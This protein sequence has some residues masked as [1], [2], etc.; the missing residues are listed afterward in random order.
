MDY[1]TKTTEYPPFTP[2]P[3][4]LFEADLSATAKLTY[5]VLLNRA[6]LSRSNDWIDEQGRVFVVYPI[7]ALGKALKKKRTVVQTAMRDLEACDRIQRVKQGLTHP[8][9]IYVKIDSP[10]P[11]ASRCSEKRTSDVRKNGRQMFGKPATN[12]NKHNYNKENYTIHTTPDLSDL[13]MKG[14]DR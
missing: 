7:E 11:S 14:D 10:A 13:L 5:L 3:N 1:I 4:S 2:C 6:L 8:N 12:Y 9:R